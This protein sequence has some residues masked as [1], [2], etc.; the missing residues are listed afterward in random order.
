MKTLE[1]IKRIL[2]TPP[3]SHELAQKYILEEYDR[4]ARLLGFDSYEH[5]KEHFNK[6]RAPTTN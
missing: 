2:E 6:H 3:I 5:A 1:E 4:Y